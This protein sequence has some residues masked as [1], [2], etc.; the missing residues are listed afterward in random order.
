M[1]EYFQALIVIF[2]SVLVLFFLNCFDS[3]D[4]SLGIM[5]IIAM[6]TSIIVIIHIHQVSDIGSISE[7]NRDAKQRIGQAIA[8]NPIA[9]KNI[10]LKIVCCLS[11]PASHQKP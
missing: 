11:S 7:L 4:P 2:L 8:I 5:N 3:E 10:T 9:I 1:E 6:I